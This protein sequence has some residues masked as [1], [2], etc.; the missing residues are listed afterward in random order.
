MAESTATSNKVFRLIFQYPCCV[1]DPNTSPFNVWITGKNPRDQYVNTTCRYLPYTVNL[2]VED[3]EL[4]DP[5]VRRIAEALRLKRLPDTTEPTSSVTNYSLKLYLK[6]DHSL[7]VDVNPM[8][9]EPK[10][11]PDIDAS[12]R[13][14]ANVMVL[15]APRI[16]GNTT[17][18]LLEYE[19]SERAVKEILALASLIQERFPQ[20]ECPCKSKT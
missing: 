19:D 5:R 11:T 2:V 18:V 6:P 17:A 1:R 13:H 16:A 15:A 4:S 7:I 12:A 3:D 10:A 14:V 9:C 20:D 8:L